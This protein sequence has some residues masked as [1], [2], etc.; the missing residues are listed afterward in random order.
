M[1]RPFIKLNAV[2]ILAT[3]L[4][5]VFIIT[6]FNY[7]T[8]V[9]FHKMYSIAT[10]VLPYV[11]FRLIASRDYYHFW[12]RIILII[13]SVCAIWQSIYA[14]L[15][16]I[17][18]CESHNFMFTITGSFHNPGPF[19]GFLAICASL[20]IP[21]IQKEAYR[22][23]RILYSAATILCIILLPATL[24]RT[25]LL[26][27]GISMLIYA[28]SF[29]YFRDTIKRYWI[30]AVVGISLL[31][32]SAYLYKKDSANGRFYINKISAIAMRNNGFK[33][34]GLGKFSRTY[35]ETQANYFAPYIDNI[36]QGDA[37]KK[38][39]Q[40]RMIADCPEYAFNEY[41]E[42]GVECGIAGI[43]TFIILTLTA[44]WILYKAK[45]IWC[46]GL[47]TLSIF[48]LFSYPFK[49]VPFC[50][51]EG[52]FIAMAGIKANKGIKTYAPI[53]ITAILAITF[54]IAGFSKIS[55]SKKAE[56]LLEKSIT[57][58]DIKYYEPF[59]EECYP[60]TKDLS[61]NYTFLFQL[62]QSLNKC[63]EYEKSDSILTLGSSISC[64]PMFWNIMG[65]NAIAQGN[66]ERAKE[67]YTKAFCMIPNR[68]Y[69]LSLLAKMYHENGDTAAFLH[70]S[71]AING[72]VPKVE[73]ELTK[74][75][76]EEINL[77]IHESY[78]QKPAPTPARY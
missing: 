21:S 36:I 2:D 58:Y 25:A 55:S 76:R 65:N 51:F 47:I 70:L 14:I 22:F 37:P 31:G 50:I 24:S 61:H 46:Y 18:I 66:Y 43:V 59:A 57:L 28:L 68:L 35:G 32:V 17:G 62:G 4:F 74:E 19:G 38:I 8:E 60:L 39:E 73:S 78:L 67:C 23:L 77:I 9:S 13:L 75:L 7:Q 12:K 40:E 42:I 52:L 16:V 54:I 48:A 5:L 15:Q 3:T 34:S 11:A 29:Q 69:P 6:W 1:K 33:G 41:M 10:Y 44:I 49:I 20:F 30:I 72:F 63:G 56:K 71:N 26:A 64:D 53:H 27:L 45:S